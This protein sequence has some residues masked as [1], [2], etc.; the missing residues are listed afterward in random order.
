MTDL[1]PVT[2][3]TGFLGAGKTTLLNRLLAAN[4]GVRFAIVENE[5]GTVGIDGALIAPQATA[6]VELSNGCICC[7]VRGELAT[8]L[9]DLL[10]KRDTG[11]LAFD[12]LLIET[13]GL[14][15]PGPVVQTFFW[16]EELRHRFQLDAVITLV[17]VCHATGQLDRER[18]AA[19]QVAYADWIILTKTDLATPDALP[20][21][22][23]AINARAPQ[24]DVRELDQHWPALLATGGFALNEK[25]LPPANLFR[26]NTVARP[27]NA[28]GGKPARSWDDAIET[29]LLEAPGS[30]DMAA[31]S[32]FVDQLVEQ[33]AHDLLRYKGI[34]SIAG[35]NKRLV[36]QGVH[37]IA[38]F[39]YG[40]P[41]ESDAERK[42]RIVLIGRDLPQDSLRAGFAA[43]AGT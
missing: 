9:A 42:S 39:D 34:L 6:I 41:W 30:V 25:G 21:R 22:L 37:R 26:H 35:E 17:D 38:G 20:T 2:L 14:A 10:S 43:C 32:A 18:V 12:R 28:L 1:I 36:F 4:P 7:S 13:T 24:L 19:A 8:S 27:L 15:D 40:R 33:H 29:V 16:E 11:E 3:L 23:A 31:V 5:F